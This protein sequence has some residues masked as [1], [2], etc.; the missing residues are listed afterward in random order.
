MKVLLWTILVIVLAI[1]GYFVYESLE[2]VPVV[3]APP[4]SSATS[5]ADI[6]VI[7][8]GT[9]SV[10]YM[11]PQYGFDI[12]YPS[13]STLRD[14]GFE[15]Y[16]PLTQTPIIAFVLSP[17]L[18]AGTN[19]SEAGVYVGATSSPAMVSN[20]L[21]ARPNSGEIAASSTIAISGMTFAQ[22]DSTGAAAGSTY[23]EKIYRTLVGS[24]CL[25][26]VELMHSSDIGNHPKSTV[27]PFDSAHI[28]AI[29]DAMMDTLTFSA[30]AQR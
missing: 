21:S 26:F 2:M 17:D 20:C 10:K 15:G 1:V 18:S 13:T 25:E 27:T 7:I 8:P 22:F 16:L 28:S 29:L 23:Q 30:P 4:G 9:P 3:I 6:P 5:T 14:G 24:S 11:D 12:Y 19:L